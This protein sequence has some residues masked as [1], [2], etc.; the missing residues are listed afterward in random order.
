MA[1]QAK[2]RLFDLY[3]QDVAA[4]ARIR[5]R[6]QLNSDALAIRVALRELAKRLQQTS[7]PE[8]TENLQAEAGPEI[9]HPAPGE[10]QNEGEPHA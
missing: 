7:Q 3:P 1:T 4:L 2:A 10:E 9:D 5:K 8:L 6:L